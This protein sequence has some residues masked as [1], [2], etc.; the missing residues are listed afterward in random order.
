MPVLVYIKDQ[1]GIHPQI[2]HEN[3]G[4]NGKPIV[5][6]AQFQH[7]EI[8]EEEA[9]IGIDALCRLHK[10]RIRLFYRRGT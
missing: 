7:H 2:I 6:L 10:Y 1:F 3:K 4:A 5:D 8:T 9:S